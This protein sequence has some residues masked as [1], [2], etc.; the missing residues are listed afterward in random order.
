LE[1]PICCSGAHC[2]VTTR[3]AQAWDGTGGMSDGSGGVSLWADR[4]QTLVWQA[5]CTELHAAFPAA[6]FK[7]E[8][9]TCWLLIRE[10]LYF[11]L[12]MDL[13]NY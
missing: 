11:L 10:G 1:E 12:V 13:E 9:P 7:K 4:L 5:V 6:L 2:S 8:F 3:N